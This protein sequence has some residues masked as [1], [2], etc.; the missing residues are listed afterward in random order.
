[1]E[2]AVLSRLK[3]TQGRSFVL[4]P[5]EEGLAIS[6]AEHRWEKCCDCWKLWSPAKSEKDHYSPSNPYSWLHRS[7]HQGLLTALAPSQLKPQKPHPASVR[8]SFREGAA[9]CPVRLPIS[10]A[11][12]DRLP[13]L[14][15]YM[16]RI[17]NQGVAGAFPS[18]D[19]SFCNL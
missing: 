13:S 17:T 16:P 19:L 2:V 7:C 10:R 1:M 5:P 12:P 4:T 11:S 15:D 18:D 8:F 14:R 9:T 6:V 3:E